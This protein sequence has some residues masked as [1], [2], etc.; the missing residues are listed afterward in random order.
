[1][2]VCTL[3]LPSPLV[4]TEA[5]P[6]PSP[7]FTLTLASPPFTLTLALPLSSDVLLELV[8]AL[9]EEDTLELELELS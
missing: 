5:S 3:A 2:S 6:L 7:P 4:S 9:D 1:M 8:L